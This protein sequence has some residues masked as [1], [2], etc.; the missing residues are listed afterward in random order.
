LNVI[1]KAVVACKNTG[2]DADYHFSHA[3]KMIDIGKGGN[4][5]Y[6]KLKKRK[7][8]SPVKAESLCL[9]NENILDK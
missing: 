5:I 7:R 3:G 1:A 8:Q 4:R 2:I 9:M 6:P